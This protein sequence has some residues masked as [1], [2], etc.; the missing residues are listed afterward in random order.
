VVNTTSV[1]AHTG[2]GIWEIAYPSAKAALS[3]HD[4][5]ARSGIWIP[6]IRGNAVSPGTI[7]TNCHKQFS[8]RGAFEAVVTA[9]PLTGVG[10]PEDIAGVVVF[11]CSEGARFVQGQM[12]EANVGFLMV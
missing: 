11:L 6:G 10:A 12:I 4:E 3:D 8:S 7:N 5:R 9:T 1:A 2:G